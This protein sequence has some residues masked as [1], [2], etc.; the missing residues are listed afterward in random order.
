MSL[1]DGVADKGYTDRL[2]VGNSFTVYNVKAFCGDSETV[3]VCNGCFFCFACICL[4][5]GSVKYSSCL[6]VTAGNGYGLVASHNTGVA[7]V[8]VC[9]ANSA[10]VKCTARDGYRN[11]AVLSVVVLVGSNFF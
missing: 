11:I 1:G 8:N 6:K 3:S 4:Y 5:L 2:F 10:A 9:V 7:C